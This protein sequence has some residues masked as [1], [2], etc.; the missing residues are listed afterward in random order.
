MIRYN[1][2]PSGGMGHF[3]NPPVLEFTGVSADEEAE[4]HRSL[5]EA[6]YAPANFYAHEWQV[7]DIVINDKIRLLTNRDEIVAV[8]AKR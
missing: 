4:F 1:E 8:I 2:P 6:L 5:R 7:G 3:V